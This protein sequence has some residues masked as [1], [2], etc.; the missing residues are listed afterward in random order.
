[1]AGQAETKTIHVRLPHWMWDGLRNEAK[2]NG[3]TVSTQI[4]FLVASSLPDEIKARPEK[5]YDGMPFR[6]RGKR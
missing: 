5:W 3:Q 2:K 1:M 4:R 6:K